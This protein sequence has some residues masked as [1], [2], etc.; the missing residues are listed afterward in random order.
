MFPEMTKQVISIL[1][2]LLGYQTD[3]WVDEAIIGFLSVF[4]TGENTLAI[5]HYSEFLVDVIHE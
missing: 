5:F 1:S 4:S 3:Q 2:C